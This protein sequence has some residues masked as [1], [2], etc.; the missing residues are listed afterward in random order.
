MEDKVTDPTQNPNPIYGGSGIDTRSNAATNSMALSQPNGQAQNLS[1]QVNTQAHQ[2][3]QSLHQAPSYHFSELVPEDVPAT[4]L[5]PSDS[6]ALFQG[7]K[8]QLTEARELDSQAENQL[9]LQ[10]WLANMRALIDSKPALAANQQVQGILGKVQDA[11]DS[12]STQDVIDTYIERLEKA[13]EMPE[14][15]GSEE[16]KQVT[17]IVPHKGGKTNKTLSQQGGLY[18]ML[19]NFVIDFL[20]TI[21]V[22][23]KM[24]GGV[25]HGADAVAGQFGV[26]LGKVLPAG[27]A[28]SLVGGLA[29]WKIAE[30]YVAW[31]DTTAE[32]A[33][34]K[35]QKWLAENKPGF[36]YSLNTTARN[37][38]DSIMNKIF[39]K[40]DSANT[41]RNELGLS[42]NMMHELLDYLPERKKMEAVIHNLEEELENNK[43]M[44]KE[45]FHHKK[46]DVLKLKD[47]MVEADNK[48]IIGLAF[49]KFG[50]K[51][52]G[53]ANFFLKFSSIVHCRLAGLANEA[54]A[55]AK[56]TLDHMGALGKVIF[57]VFDNIPTGY[58]V[59]R[60]GANYVA[61]EFGAVMEN[62]E[63]Y[64][65]NNVVA[66]QRPGQPV[67]VDVNH[68]VVS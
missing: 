60:M 50:L 27:L 55:A 53:V 57:H 8:K 21:F 2:H 47:Q 29:F 54:A 45:D 63:D 11:V 15:M 9:N 36:V 12:N 46:A 13:W 25:E 37:F 62:V 10:K 16:A 52:P 20:N 5:D 51:L 34:K 33:D 41:P 59:L 6:A 14:A 38:V 49:D 61:G 3:N 48:R 44:S 24:I 64:A 32:S 1:P 22:P 17:D 65:K 66:F 28:K 23:P 68:T 26:N 40:S 7:L 39:A 4:A 31:A 43:Q 67:T 18:R 58:S 56:P 19:V 30:P 35:S 42:E